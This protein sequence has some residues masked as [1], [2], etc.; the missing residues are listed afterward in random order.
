M[1]WY[2]AKKDQMESAS[3]GD[4][5]S[6]P[7]KSNSLNN[8]SCLCFMV[9]FGIWRTWAP[10]NASITLVCIGGSGTHVA[11]IA[12]ATGSSSSGSGYMP[13]YFSIPQRHSCC[14]CTILYKYSVLPGP[15]VRIHLQH[16]WFESSH[17][18]MCWC[19]LF[20]NLHV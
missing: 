9:S 17:L 6:N 16:V 20:P 14:H 19:N 12:L 13:C 2:S 15:G 4:Q 3:S 10:S 18:A 11:M 1:L 7:L 5:D 8:F